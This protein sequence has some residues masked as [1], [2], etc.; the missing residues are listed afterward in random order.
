MTRR[1]IGALAIVIGGWM[2]LASPAGASLNCEITPEG[3]KCEPVSTTTVAPTTTTTAPT[4]TTT[5]TTPPTTTPPTTT[6][7]TTPPT[8]APPTTVAPTTT[9]RPTPTAR[10]TTTTATTTQP[11]VTIPPTTT[12]ELPVT[13]TPTTSE[14]T[15]PLAGDSGD[16]DSAP[17]SSEVVRNEAGRI[18]ITPTGDGDGDD[19]GSGTA[20]A[21]VGSE[22]LDDA[23]NDDESGTL[24]SLAVGNAVVGDFDEQDNSLLF[25]L[26]PVIAGVL[27]VGGVVGWTLV[28][29]RRPPSLLAVHALD[30]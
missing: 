1:V 4:T 10:P 11:T 24:E 12:V 29:T 25:L 8:T 16:D 6:T 28:Q 7:T 5:T 14:T 13:G 19:S 23:A 18:D 3:E 2:F 17:T 30:D 20:A 26:I 22:D 27:I 21:E 15:A 9:A